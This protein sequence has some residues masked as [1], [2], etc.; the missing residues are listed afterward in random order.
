M[1]V[2][3]VE[4]AGQEARPGQSKQLWPG[5]QCGGDVTVA[6]DCWSNPLVSR[7]N[8]ATVTKTT[9]C[10]FRSPLFMANN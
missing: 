5:L 8:G 6:S 3:R 7:G 2:R 4:T 10:L 9:R 1:N